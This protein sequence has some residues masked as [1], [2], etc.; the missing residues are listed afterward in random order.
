[1]A[2]SIDAR[3]AQHAGELAGSMPK[4]RPELRTDRDT[5]AAKRQTGGHPHR[6]AGSHA[7]ELVTEHH[8]KASKR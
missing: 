1:M 3:V 4:H 8:R 7:G 5:S 6:L 2:K